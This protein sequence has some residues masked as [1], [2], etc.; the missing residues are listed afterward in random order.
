METME[1]K[2][3]LITVITPLL[4]HKDFVTV[5]ENQDSMGIL[6]TL[7]VHKDDMG[8][9]LGRKGE[10]ATAFRHLVRI[11]GRKEDARVSVKINEPVK[12][13]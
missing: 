1:V 5:T 2:E 9:L 12:T 10:T 11:V 8:I 13:G 4:K 6:L 7:T 3:Y